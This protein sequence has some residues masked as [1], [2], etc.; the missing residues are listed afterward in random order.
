M[1]LFFYV[2]WQRIRRNP[3]FPGFGPTY[4]SAILVLGMALSP[5]LNGSFGARDCQI[6]VI[7]ANEQIGSYLRTVISS[8]SLVYWDGGL[9]AVPLLY[10]PDVKIFPAQINSGYSFINGGDT[11]ELNRFG[12]WN[13]EMDAEWKSTADYFI[14]EEARYAGWKAFLNSEQFVEFQPTPAAT[15]CVEKTRLRIFR[16]K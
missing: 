11:A 13:A 16:R 8:G 7:K 1:T 14:I 6:D 9:S 15:S 2:V 10:L 5:V 3:G 12:F 4:S